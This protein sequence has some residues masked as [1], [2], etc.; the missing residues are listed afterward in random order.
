[1]GARNEHEAGGLH[2]QLRRWGSVL[3][4][5]PSARRAPLTL[6]T[7]T[8][9]PPP[10]RRP[11]RTFRLEMLGRYARQKSKTTIA[12]GFLTRDTL[13]LFE[14]GKSFARRHAQHFFPLPPL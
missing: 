13:P 10:R 7:P 12:I 14:F 9:T 2:A 6:V 1:M 3:H 8:T 11:R 4:G 5:G